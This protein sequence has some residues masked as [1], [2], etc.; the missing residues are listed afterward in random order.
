M[1]RSVP[2]ANV[3]LLLKNIN[4]VVA[5]TDAVNGASVIKLLGLDGGAS[6][7]ADAPCVVDAPFGSDGDIALRANRAIVSEA[8]GVDT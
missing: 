7:A 4:A 3:L 2:L 6:T 5:G 1:L 8:V